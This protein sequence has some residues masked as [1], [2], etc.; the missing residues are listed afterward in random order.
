VGNCD[1]GGTSLAMAGTADCF[2]LLPF[3]RD[4]GSWRE[5]NF[6]HPPNFQS[7]IAK[8]FDPSNSTLCRVS[9][10]GGRL[11]VDRI[12]CSLLG[13][14]RNI[15]TYDDG[16][17]STDSRPFPDRSYLTGQAEQISRTVTAIDKCRE[18]NQ[19]K[20]S[21]L[22][23]EMQRCDDVQCFNGSGASRDIHEI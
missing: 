16:G 2:L 7:L 17:G 15:D 18:N 13:D 12:D 20:K 19:P 21:S 5:A 10:K 8:T 9:S 3:Q 14:G 11:Q 23:R 4:C 22:A 1:P 6:A